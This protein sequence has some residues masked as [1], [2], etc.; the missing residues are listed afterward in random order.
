MS[1]E[2]LAVSKNRGMPA[3]QPQFSMRRQYS[4]V[5][6]GT[7]LVLAV[8]GGFFIV[9]S[10]T[11]M[12]YANTSN[13]GEAVVL[14]NGWRAAGGHSVYGM[15]EEPPFAFCIYGPV[16]PYLAGLT[17]YIFGPTFVV[18]RLLSLAACL[19]SGLV[20]FLFV[21]R[22]TF[23]SSAGLVAVLVALGVRYLSWI[24]ASAVVDYPALFFSLL[25]LYLWRGGG[26]RQ[27][28][29]LAAFV[30][31]FFTK[32][33]ALAAAAAAFMALFLE[34]RRGRA[35]L[36]FGLFLLGIG[37]GLAVCRAAFGRAYFVNT[38]SYVRFAPFYVST[39]VRR[40]GAAIVV[41]AAPFGWWLYMAA[42]SYR[43]RRLLLVVLYVL[44]ALSVALTSGRDGAGRQYLFEF[45]AG[46][47]IVSG[48]L[49]KAIAV[50]ARE[51]RLGWPVTVAA[52]LQLCLFLGGSLHGSHFPGAMDKRFRERQAGV[53][54]AFRENS[55]IMVSA[56]NAMD[57]GA[58]SRNFT[59]DP[60]KFAQLVQAGV[61]SKEKFVEPIRQRL[62]S[63]IILPGV[64]QSKG[65]WML[66]D[67][68]TRET[69]AANY[70]FAYEVHGNLFFLPKGAVGD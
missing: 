62:F 8:L 43:R 33:A 41:F 26:R 9:R 18:I 47:G 35:V 1:D 4:L 32:Q 49:W 58:E 5:V 53:A 29:A 70:D 24:P 36:L 68:R 44:F 20:I 30:V 7:A 65:Q 46:M 37:L 31:A 34:G 6:A 67:E 69:V 39:M 10:I 38:F 3:L 42:K 2:G 56:Y 14:T 66:F 45:A 21:R 60:F 17:M 27:Y 25:G 19:G 16:M 50:R 55:G 64:D 59:S 63:M 22:E 51:S 13:G 15:I 57:V 48:L 61:I 40:V 11:H 52:A 23:S 28:V 12:S 54:K